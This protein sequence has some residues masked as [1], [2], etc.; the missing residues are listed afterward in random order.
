M[1]Q[2]FHKTMFWFVPLFTFTKMDYQIDLRCQTVDNIVSMNYNMPEVRRLEQDVANRNPDSFQ[3]ATHFKSCAPYAPNEL[4][5]F[6]PQNL[7]SSLGM[8]YQCRSLFDYN[9]SVSECT[10]INQLL[11]QA[12]NSRMFTFPSYL[13]T[14]KGYAD[15]L[16]LYVGDECSQ[17]ISI[18]SPTLQKFAL[19]FC[20]GQVIPVQSQ[21]WLISSDYH[22]DATG[23]AGFEFPPMTLYQYYLARANVTTCLIANEGEPHPFPHFFLIV[24]LGLLSASNFLIDIF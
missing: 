3:C 12:L 9:A 13:L 18:A 21:S 8:V 1:S 5:G 6:L 19:L 7:S 4:F 14:P 16:S 20:Y 11:N 10:W 22:I 17:L 23:R 15:L 24:C 2:F